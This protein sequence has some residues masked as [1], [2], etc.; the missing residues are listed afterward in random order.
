M[1][2]ELFFILSG[3]A[4]LIGSVA[5][6]IAWAAILKYSELCKM[7]SDVAKVT[8]DHKQAIDSLI[9]LTGSQ[10]RAIVLFARKIYAQEETLSSL[11]E[12]LVTQKQVA[13][14]VHDA[15]TREAN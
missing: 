11:K 5:C 12:D 15:I 3:L 8:G 6:I 13:A 2:N 1:N 14:L 4:L 9:N 10:D 7:I